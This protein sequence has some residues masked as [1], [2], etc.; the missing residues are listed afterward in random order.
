MVIGN[1]QAGQ[2]SVQLF[3]RRFSGCGTE[4]FPAFL[5]QEITQVERLCFRVFNDQ[6]SRRRLVHATS[7][8][9]H[10]NSR[11]RGAMAGSGRHS[12]AAPR[13][14]ASAG[15]PYTTAVDSCSAMVWPPV[16]RILS[17]PAAP[18][19]PMPVRSTPNAWLPYVSARD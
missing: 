13:R 9:E 2:P 6:D 3:E 19:S 10:A 18:S 14:T 17:N 15:M 16:L 8:R 5:L 1:D 11:S 7:F 12:H 4:H